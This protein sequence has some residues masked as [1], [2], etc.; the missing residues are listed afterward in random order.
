MAMDLSQLGKSSTTA[1]VG[2]IEI[3]Y[4]KQP[5]LECE[6]VYEDGEVW[7]IIPSYQY[8]SLKKYLQFL[9]LPVKK[10]LLLWNHIDVRLVGQYLKYSLNNVRRSN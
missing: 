5:S 8:I 10:K 7:V 3:D 2:G 9:R 1:K 4:L 6:E